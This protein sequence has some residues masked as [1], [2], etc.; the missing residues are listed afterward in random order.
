MCVGVVSVFLFIMIGWVRKGLMVVE[1]MLEMVLLFCF[2]MWVCG[3][4]C[5]VLLFVDVGE[6]D[7]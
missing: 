3:D 6:F 1:G 5:I 2:D 7:S 4:R